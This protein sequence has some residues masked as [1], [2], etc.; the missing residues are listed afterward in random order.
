MLCQSHVRPLTHC[1]LHYLYTL[2]VPLTA[3]FVPAGYLS[4]TPPHSP[5]Q[6]FTDLVLLPQH[7]IHR[8]NPPLLVRRP[9]PSLLNPPFWVFLF[10]YIPALRNFAPVRR[11][12]LGP[13]IALGCGHALVHG[14]LQCGRCE[15]YRGRAGSACAAT[16]R[17]CAS[18]GALMC[19]PQPRH[20]W[21]WC[22]L[23]QPHPVGSDAWT[24]SSRPTPRS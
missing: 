8:N 19:L 12:R 5:A 20:R 18:H 15:P 16:Y 13:G 24:G 14:E 4:A 3:L 17:A 11:D 1:L 22:S 21:S 2:F 7:T 10:Y 9:T 23:H 6:P